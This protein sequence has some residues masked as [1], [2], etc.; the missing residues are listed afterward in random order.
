MKLWISSTSFCSDSYSAVSEGKSTTS[1]R[2]RLFPGEYGTKRWP[3]AR[4][5]DLGKRSVGQNGRC[6][7]LSVLFLFSDLL[8]FLFDLFAHA[9]GD[10]IL[11]SASSAS[12][13]V[14]R[15]IRMRKVITSP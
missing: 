12:G 11:R 15:S 13:K 7:W 2:S 14:R 9:A 8:N 1:L 5:F 4:R 3:P 10:A 6:G